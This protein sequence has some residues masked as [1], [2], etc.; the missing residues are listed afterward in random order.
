MIMAGLE[1]MK[2]I[3]FKDVYFHSIVRDSKGQKMSKTL[4]NYSDPIELM[5]TYGTDA[6]KFHHQD[7]ERGKN[8]IYEQ[9][10]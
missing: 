10:N 6:L 9:R 4:G 3:P 1:Y 2:E 8:V 7:L 5:N